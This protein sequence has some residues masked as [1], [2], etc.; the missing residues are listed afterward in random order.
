MVSDKFDSIRPYQ[1]REEEI[2]ALN[3]I[4][5]HPLLERISKYLY[6]EKNPKE[7]GSSISKL[8]SVDDFQSKIM[9]YAINRIIEKTSNSLSFSGIENLDNNKKY[10]FISNHRDILLDSGIIQVILY[11]NGFQTS[12]MAVGDNLITDSFIE[13]IARS[14]KM[15]K[16]VRSTNPRELY[17]S[18]LLLSEYIRAKISENSSSIWIAQRNGRT[19]NGID[20]TEQGL[21]KM[22]DMSGKGDFMSDF[23]QLNIVPISISYEYEPCDILK[24]RETFISSKQ[25][26][27]KSPGEDLN[28]ILTGIMQYKGDI[29]VHFGD[30]LNSNEIH[31]CSLLEKNERYKSLSEVIDNKIYQG[32]KLWPNNKIAYDLVNNSTLF[33]NEYSSSQKDKF[34]EYI[35]SK[36]L[37]ISTD[38]SEIKD[39][40]LNIYSN[41]VTIKNR[42]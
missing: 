29:H 26:Y 7:L 2:L 33:N 4:G 17:S 38:K 31:N 12:E 13:D 35:D 34:I 32:Y 10:L 1:G 15:I 20:L 36:L 40:L 3:R 28:S 19:K 22:L 25:K 39:R 27:I 8:E 41:P 23:S 30:K 5:S 37:D 42:S 14:N 24:A 18:S 16:V 6:P 9:Y 21:L 11:K